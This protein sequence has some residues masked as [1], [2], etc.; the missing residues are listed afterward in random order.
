VLLAGVHGVPAAS[1]ITC[2]AKSNGLT[3][4]PHWPTVIVGGVHEAEAAF[5]R[6]S[7]T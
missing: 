5:R 6:F 1:T 2:P 4:A 3:W 7:D